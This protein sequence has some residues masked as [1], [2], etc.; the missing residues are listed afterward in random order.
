MINRVLIRIKVV[1]MLY[2]YMLTKDSKTID[3][4][5]DDLRESLDKSYELYN[6]LLGLVVDLT[7]LETLR[8]DDAKHKFLPTEEDLNPNTR[9]VD[10]ELADADA[11]TSVDVPKGFYVV[12]YNNQW[13]RKVVVK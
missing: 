1:Q 11:H 3:K 13:S 6:H 10:N 8:L 12:R 7:D 9:F 2:S 4:A 5:K